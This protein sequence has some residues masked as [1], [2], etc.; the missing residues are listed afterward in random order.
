M[1]LIKIAA[2]TKALIKQ[3]TTALGDKKADN[4]TVL[5]LRGVSQSLEFFVLATGTSTPHLKALGATVKDY[6][7][8]S[9]GLRPEHVEGPSDRWVLLSYGPVVVHLFSPEARAYYD[10]ESLWA[11]AERVPVYPGD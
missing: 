5:D 6:L 4:I 1:P 3:I 10:L 7:R 9:E 8:S 2:D 11:D